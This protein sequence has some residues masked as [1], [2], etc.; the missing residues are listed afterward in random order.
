MV[1]V[2]S[3]Y[4]L[5]FG[6]YLSN[7]ALLLLP[8]A[9]TAGVV[10]ALAVRSRGWLPRALLGGYVTV[11]G[12]ILLVTLTPG[13][14][15]RPGA[16]SCSLE[17]GA[18]LSDSW[19]GHARLLNVLMFVP[20]GLLGAALVRSWRTPLVLALLLTFAVEL[21]QRELPAIRRSCDVVDL[22]DNTLGA[23]IGATVGLLLVGLAALLSARAR[24]SGGQ[25]SRDAGPPAVD[26]AV[27]PAGRQR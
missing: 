6:Y 3:D 17:F 22:A 13:R 9:L 11:V 14:V 20:L 12:A 27:L 7:I 4:H 8:V 21:T 16:G 5:F 15:T 25:M 18:V 10:V 23:V 19:S 1:G 24:R 2:A 26:Q